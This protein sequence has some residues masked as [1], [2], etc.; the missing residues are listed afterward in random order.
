MSDGAH[1][2]VGVDLD[3]MI[4]S[5][6]F[7]QTMAYLSIGSIDQDLI[8]ILLACRRVVLIITCHFISIISF[9]NENT[10]DLSIKGY[11]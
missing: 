1:N 3:E 6:I 2:D 7:D 4:I 9:K 5:E 8:L 10:D 11:Y